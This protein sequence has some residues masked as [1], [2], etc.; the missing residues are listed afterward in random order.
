M[1]MFGTQ[2][3][4]SL[5][6]MKPQKV[7][8]PDMNF[9]ESARDEDL[10]LVDHLHF[11]SPKADWSVISDNFCLLSGDKK[12]VRFFIQTMHD[13]KIQTERKMRQEVEQRLQSIANEPL[14]VA[15]G[16]PFMDKIRIIGRI[17]K[18]HEDE[19][20]SRRESLKN[21]A[22]FFDNSIL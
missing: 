12:R 4:Q 13:A 20:N 15:F 11:D 22:G 2:S 6:D 10:A 1:N 9:V 7:V 19:K 5:I 16:K 18:Q 3:E 21:L 14:L 8:D 17:I